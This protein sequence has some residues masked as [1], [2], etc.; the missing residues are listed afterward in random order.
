MRLEHFPWLGKM[1]ITDVPN[2]VCFTE[3]L[4]KKP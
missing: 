3:V 2:K 1:Q 4:E